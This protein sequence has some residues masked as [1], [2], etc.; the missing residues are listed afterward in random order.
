MVERK[1]LYCD[2]CSEMPAVRVVIT[3][4]DDKG[5]KDLCEKCREPAQTLLDRFQS[6]S[7]AGTVSF[8]DVKHEL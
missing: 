2:L 3:I 8:A 7:S 1:V 5:A 4:G 6:K